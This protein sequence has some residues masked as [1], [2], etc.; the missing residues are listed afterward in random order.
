MRS[1]SWSLALGL[2]LASL[3]VHADDPYSALKL[4]EINSEAAYVK[5]LTALELARN[6]LAKAKGEKVAGS[7]DVVIM[8]IER[9]SGQTIARLQLENGAPI[10]V[11][12]GDRLP[13]GSAVT[14]IRPN[15]VKL[16]KGKATR[17]LAFISGDRTASP[18]G[19]TAAYPAFSPL[20]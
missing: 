18:A 13:D 19:P 14:E 9:F 6:D 7:G 3:S 15:G 16:M 12:P 5:A 4:V 8:A 20:K 10:E 11:H 1:K 17:E 2:L